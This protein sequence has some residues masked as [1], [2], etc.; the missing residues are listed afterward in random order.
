MVNLLSNK[1]PYYFLSLY[2][3]DVS[4]Y[5]LALIIS[6]LVFTDSHLTILHE[7][8]M[9]IRL[10]LIM[11]FLL[12]INYTHH[13]L[14]DDKRNTFN[15]NDFMAIIY[16]VTTVFFISF[17]II[18][19]FDIFNSVPAK[20]FLLSYLLLIIL[21]AGARIM[22][23]KIVIYARNKGVDIKNFILF[24][25]DTFDLVSKIDENKA[26]GYKL[27]KK[28]NSISE[29]ES[30]LNQADIVFISRDN[31][32]SAMMSL[33]LKN[34]HITWKII[35]GIFNLVIEDINFDEFRDCPVM[36]IS[37]G[38]AAQDYL[39]KKRIIDIILSSLALVVLSP[40][41]LVVAIIM[42]TTM[43]GPLF[44]KHKRIGKDMKEFTI[45]KFRSMIIGADDK[46]KQMLDQNEVKGLFKIKDDPRITKFGKILR[47]T[48]I[49]E[50]A[51]II[52]IF[53]GDMSIVGPRPH[54]KDEL[55]SFS[56]WRMM[57]FNI[58]PGLT[59]IWQISGRH[60]LNFDKAVLYDLYYIKHMSF[61]LDVKIILKTIPAIIF[62]G[63]RW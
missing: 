38:N 10:A 22:L 56:D 13:G 11:M 18:I 6:F 8:Q 54:L 5:L 46:K 19:A 3:S 59:G 16:S 62:S 41:F 34:N 21:T 50:L 25:N 36:N 24:G 43:P 55:P 45:Y 49:D 31:I 63:G 57:R 61:F 51:Q 39:K 14:Y 15:D 23:S 44:F 17:I 60:Q 29:L 33:I 7:G 58:K 30:S 53:K 2:L 28:T 4:M 27:V 37:S 20:F 42:K 48:C 9:H 1:K 47:K 32:N 12:I 52:N 40:L 26:L 35:P